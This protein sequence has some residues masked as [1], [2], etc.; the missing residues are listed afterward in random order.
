MPTAPIIVADLRGGRNGIDSPIDPNFPNN[1]CCEAMNVDFSDGPLGRRRGGAD[2]VALTGGTAFAT[3]I[4]QM[5]TWV[6]DGDETLAE[7][8]AVD[9]AGLIKRMAA[10]TA[11]ADVTLD[12]AITGSAQDIMFAALNGKLYIAYKSAVDRLH[13]YDRSLAV[14]RVRRVG[15]NPGTNVPTVANTGG[16]AYANVARYYRVRFVQMNGAI[17][18]RRSEPTLVSAVFTPSG[19]G[20][21]ARITRPT[22]P[23]EGETHWEIDV[24]LNNSVF[25]KLVS[26]AQGN[27]VAIATTTFDDSVVT[28]IYATTLAAPD[29]LGTYTLPPSAKSIV[30]DDNRLIMTG[31][32]FDTTFSSRIWITPV[33][34]SSDQ[35]DDERIVD[36]LTLKTRID[37]NEKDGGAMLGL[38][39]SVSGV[40]LGFKYRRLSKLVVTGDNVTPYL[41]RR[42]SQVIGALNQDSIVMAEDVAGNPTAYFLSFRGPYRFGINGLEY[43]GRDIEDQWRGLNGK[44]AINLE[45]TTKVCHGK[46]YANLGQIWWW[47]ATG[48]SNVPNVKL[49]LDV[50]QATLTDRFGVRGGWAIH[51]GATAVAYCSVMA[52]NTLGAA[53]SRD[54]KPYIG[55][56]GPLIYKCD[57]TASDDVGT[58]YQA[59]VKTKSLVPASKI[60]KLFT[61]SETILTAKTSANSIRQTIIKDF[62]PDGQ[63]ADVNL[64]PKGVETRLTVKI[65]GGMSSD[66]GVVQIQLGDQLALSASSWSLDALMV[67]LAEDGDA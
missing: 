40:I 14:P 7:V 5:F 13:C 6:P 16:G 3:A 34:G 52:P 45:A 32:Y 49:V 30:S 42:V 47:I 25:Y 48:S 1:Q 56:A 29:T 36:T 38:S 43:M 55:L 27:H 63:V 17:V 31:H 19:A 23:G 10:G 9:S 59:Y 39:E 64:Y 26:V 41:V 33:L 4:V 46:Y 28:T 22:P 58:G 44:S 12:D 21:A 66:M 11:W 53:M 62:E 54:R 2:N 20:T 50:H 15:I 8:W 51:D 57:T 65:D 61:A 35:G 18:V 37:L 24:S 60:G 67:P